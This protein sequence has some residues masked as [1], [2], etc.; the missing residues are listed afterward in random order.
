[1]V[2]IAEKDSKLNNNIHN[3]IIAEAVSIRFFPFLL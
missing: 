2:V 3:D 1:M